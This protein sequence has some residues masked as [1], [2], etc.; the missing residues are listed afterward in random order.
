MTQG[1]L[2]PDVELPPDV[3]QLLHNLQV[4]KVELEMQNHELR[5]AQANL[6]ASQ[7]RYFKLYDLAPIGYFTLDDE[8][9]L[10]SANSC[11][12]RLL[13]RAPQAVIGRPLSAFLSPAD[14]DI[15]F[16]HRRQLRATREPQACDLR[17]LHQD[18]EACWV[19]LE[20]SMDRSEADAPLCRATVSDINERKRAE[21]ALAASEG[22]HRML[23]AQSRDALM[24]L[25]APEWRF[26]AGNA[27]TVSMFGA[28]SESDFLARAPACYSPEHQPD[29]RRS[30][31]K[32]A[33]MLA[34]AMHEGSHASE[35]TYRRLSGEEFPATVVLTRMEISG[36]QLV[37]ATVRDETETK[38]LRLRL[39]QSE[40][41][42]SMGLLAAG[43]AHEINNPLAYVLHNVESLAQ[44]LPKLGRQPELLDSMLED[45]TECA[46]EALDGIARIKHIS[47]T[48]GAFARVESRERAPVD[49]VRAID[50]A[51]TMAFNQIK[52]KAGLVRDLQR[53]PAVWAS[54]GK[55][56]QVFLN[57]LINAAHAI[58][59]GEADH[60]RITVRTWTE[61]DDV[62]AEV[63]DTGRGMAPL[64][65]TRIFEPFFTTKPAGTGSGLGLSICK[66]ILK[67]FGGDIQVHSELGK[68]TR[69][70]VRLPADKDEAHALPAS[71]SSEAPPLAAL[72][73][74]I[75]VVDDEPGIRRTVTRILKRQHTIVGASSASEARAL[76]E[77][78][79]SFDLIL[80]DMMMP[81]M[82]GTALHEWLTTRYPK[83]ASHVV[84]MS[85][86]VF[87]P[88]V[89]EYVAKAGNLR[90][91]KPFDA[92]LLMRLVAKRIASARAG[93]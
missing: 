29:G 62:L 58:G 15:Y 57:L 81:G 72:H 74:R 26:T 20:A 53:V 25:A 16:H 22:L 33:A 92:A 28:K 49:V 87:T 64:T 30:T 83:L 60:N 45:L 42:A 36:Q 51:I 4:H 61:G 93:P 65:L 89:A 77:G 54:E 91:E 19:R 52:Y 6:K 18:G 56:S 32:G 38:L 63:G 76:L 88:K 8:G 12:G 27:T 34:R 85:G 82:S 90:I 44:E 39:G 14:Q 46:R 37:Q 2:S 10:V 48:L 84:F 73:G 31:E 66:S 43:I 78:D 11:A 71:R 40:R 21:T 69:F 75:L 50:C 9:V 47:S 86:G 7:E 41:L 80:C 23:F 3:E 5:Q 79:Q 70:I 24:T 68:G 13:G 1:Q 59:E 17:L 35:W 55:L 67:E